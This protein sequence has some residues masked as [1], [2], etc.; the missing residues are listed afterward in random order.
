MSAAENTVLARRAMEEIVDRRNRAV[1][2]ALSVPAVDGPASAAAGR[3]SPEGTNQFAT[4]LR[5]ALFHQ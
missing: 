5:S 4:M 1:V 3:R 2:D